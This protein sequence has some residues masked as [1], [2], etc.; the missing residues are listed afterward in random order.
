[1]ANAGVVDE[2]MIDTAT[3]GKNIETSFFSGISAFDDRVISEHCKVAM[4]ELRHIETNNKDVV[5]CSAVV[6]E[7]CHLFSGECFIKFFTKSKFPKLADCII[8]IQSRLNQ[9]NDD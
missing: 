8:K 7:H 9:L 3:A 2:Q 1:M 5:I 6:F 4:K